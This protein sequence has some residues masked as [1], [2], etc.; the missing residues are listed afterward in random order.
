[1]TQIP[2]QLRERTAGARFLELD[3]LRGIA[4]FTV[5][6][7][8]FCCMYDLKEK[9]YLL[10]LVAGHSAVLLFFVLS[11]FVLSLPFWNKG[12]FGRYDA[13]LVRRIFRIYVPYV[14]AVGLAAVGMLLVGEKHL[15]LAPGT[16]RHGSTL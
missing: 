5:I 2:E 15:P 14:A 10:P 13:Y 9:P 12:T 16:T 4:A 6:L 8:H 7:H 1:M 11:G 3:G